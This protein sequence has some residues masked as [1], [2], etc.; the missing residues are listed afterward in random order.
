MKALTTTTYSSSPSTM[1]AKSQFKSALQ[2]QILKF[3][4]YSPYHETLN[5]W[6]SM[7]LLLLKGFYALEENL[8]PEFIIYWLLAY[9]MQ[10]PD[11]PGHQHNKIKQKLF[12]LLNTSEY[13]A[14]ISLS[15]TST[16]AYL[17]NI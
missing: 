11:L 10:W 16:K 3:F 1:I 6:I 13:C 9:W 8:M 14:N 15:N 12:N 17:S 4:P 7:V 5:A 2:K